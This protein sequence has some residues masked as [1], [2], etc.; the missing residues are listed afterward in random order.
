MGVHTA[1]SGSAR[2][3]V[4]LRLRYLISY[5]GCRFVVQEKPPVIYATRTQGRRSNQHAYGSLTGVGLSALQAV[6]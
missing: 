6:R 1:E 5:I 2:D 4:R 3:G